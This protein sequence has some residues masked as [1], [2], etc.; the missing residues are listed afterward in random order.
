M[1]RSFVPAIAPVLSLACALSFSGCEGISPSDAAFDAAGLSVSKPV[2]ASAE[3]VAVSVTG[4]VVAVDGSP[5]GAGATALAYQGI[6]YYVNGAALTEGETVTVSGE[7]APIIEW[8]AAG[9]SL[10]YGYSVTEA[11]VTVS[12]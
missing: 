12:G 10:F 3:P 6:P 7:A 8:D 9:N 2:A 4:L 5:A 11:K 1:K